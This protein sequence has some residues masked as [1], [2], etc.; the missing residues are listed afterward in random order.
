MQQL[1]LKKK[2]EKTK[3]EA[4]LN[5]LKSWNIEAELKTSPVINKKKSGFSLSVGIWKDYNIDANE[6]GQKAWKRSK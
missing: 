5:F 4:L 2:I 6:I 3:M 1:I